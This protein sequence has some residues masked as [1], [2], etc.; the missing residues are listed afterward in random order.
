MTYS[1]VPYNPYNILLS[2]ARRAGPSFR[3]RGA[4][5]QTRAG[6]EYRVIVRTLNAFGLWAHYTT[7]F[8]VFKNY[9]R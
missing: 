1:A 5:G 4:T 6:I 8:I 3:V 9:L 2:A 7:Q